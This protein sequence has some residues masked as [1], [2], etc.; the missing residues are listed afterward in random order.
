MTTQT[1]R[2]LFQ[3]QKVEWLDE[4]RKTATSLLKHKEHI[5][6]E[7]VLQVCPKPTYLKSNVIGGVFQHPDFKSVGFTLAK[8][9]SSHKRV[10]R[11]W[12]LAVQAMAPVA[13]EERFELPANWRAYKR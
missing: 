12:T 7:D 5:T 9:P 3:Q 8:K 13:R 10:I 1:A 6:I 4:A 2:D 11:Q